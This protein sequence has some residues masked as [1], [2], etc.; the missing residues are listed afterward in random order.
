MFNDVGYKI[1]SWA[2]AFFA[3][4]TILSLIGGVTVI[5]VHPFSYGNAEIGD[6]LLCFGIVIFGILFAWLISLF[7][8]ACGENNENLKKI[9]EAA[10]TVAS[11]AMKTSSD[12]ESKPTSY[13]NYATNDEMSDL[14][15]HLKVRRIKN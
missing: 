7:I 6:V 8:Y 12:S 14:P 5:L 15:Y 10:S 9:A 2:K 11:E 3:I 1:M 13:F 4:N